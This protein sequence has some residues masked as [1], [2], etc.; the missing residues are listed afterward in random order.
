LRRVSPVPDPDRLDRAADKNESVAR[1]F[2]SK[3]DEIATSTHGL[4]QRM[5]VLDAR[6]DGVAQS[7]FFE[8][9]EEEKR[10]THE[11]TDLL[12]DIAS[13][14]RGIAGNLRSR[15][16]EERERRRREEERR[17]REE[18]ERRRREEAAGGA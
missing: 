3:S 16:A 4:D 2:D 8:D 7:R 15:A 17:R 11:Y 9:W 6:W 13:D 18:E 5:S 12:E 14:L 10:K 1:Q